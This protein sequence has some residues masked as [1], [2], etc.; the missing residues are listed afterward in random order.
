MSRPNVWRSEFIIDTSGQITCTADSAFHDC[1]D[2]LLL[3]DQ[4]LFEFVLSNRELHSDIPYS[5]RI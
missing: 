1:W 5:A 4:C 3:L 2:V